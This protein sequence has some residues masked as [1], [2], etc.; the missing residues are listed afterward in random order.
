MDFGNRIDE[1]IN[2]QVLTIFNA[3]SE[4]HMLWITDLVP[5]YSSLAIYYNALLLPPSADNSYTEYERAVHQL[6]FFL[7][8]DDGSRVTKQSRQISIPVCYESTC[9]PDLEEVAKLSGVS[10][11]EVIGL[12]TSTIFRVYMI[13]FLPGFAYMGEV[14]ATIAVARRSEPRIKVPA[15]SVGIAGKQTGIYPFGSPGGWQIIGKTPVSLFN[16]TAVTPTFFLP[17]DEIKFYPITGNEFT[18]Y[19]GGIV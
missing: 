15:G 3:L 17:G 12:H 5:A 16:K 6:Q 11:D 19:K 9:A 4:A 1:A 14:P 18:H 7:C 8:T 13:G 10:V 2:R